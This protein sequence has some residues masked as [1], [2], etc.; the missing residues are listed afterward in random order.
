MKVVPC[1][2][3]AWDSVA[4]KTDSGP[5]LYGAAFFYC[6]PQIVEVF[7]RK[8]RTMILVAMIVVVGMV[9]RKELQT[10][11]SH[12]AIP[13]KPQRILSFAPSVTETLHAMGLGERIVGVTQFCT[14]PPEV[15]RLPRVAGFSDINFEAVV[16]CRPDLAVLPIDKTANAEALEN[17]GI[18]VLTL[19]TRSL[20]GFLQD[21]TR[22]GV[23]TGRYKEAEVI[24]NSF[25][26]A[27]AAAQ[28]RAKGV[29]RPRV[30]FSIMHSYQG[31]GYID[32]INAIGR[33]GFY[34]E[35]IEAAGGDN[36]YDG[37][38]A[39]P[40]LSR[41]AIIF[42]NPDVIID[43]IPT[44]E[45]LAEIKQDWESLHNVS[46][47]RNGQLYFLTDVADTVPGP[48]SVQTL[49]HLSRA[50]YP[51]SSHLTASDKGILP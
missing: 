7:M 39:F 23:V 26:S 48:R 35:L 32:E 17:L 13:D 37:Q 40:R 29:Q 49:E 21:L 36:V 34:N 27:L 50:F 45:N 8:I 15:S 19:D 47:I 11:H 9:I 2:G 12:P 24:T 22:L 43:V 3:N 38:L 44:G 33:D 1:R 31:L 28:Q 10:F 16:R 30:L 18:P 14:W 6:L 20:Q 25:H 41:E 51:Q 46:A 5:F 42:L 4:I